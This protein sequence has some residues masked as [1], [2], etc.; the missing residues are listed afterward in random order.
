[1]NE[2]IRDEWVRRLEGGDYTQ[3]RT[4]LRIGDEYCC[5]GVLCEM[6]VEAGV[7][8]RVPNGNFFGYTN[9]EARPEEYLLPLPVMLWAGLDTVNPWSQLLEE[10]LTAMNDSGVPF[11]EIAQIIRD[12]F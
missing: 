3:G 1:M 2:E 9:G 11:S 5:L 8:R 4:A 10:G 7:V 12:E 6:A